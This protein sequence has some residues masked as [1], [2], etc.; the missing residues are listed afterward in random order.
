MRDEYIQAARDALEAQGG[1]VTYTSGQVTAEFYAV[2][3]PGVQMF[4]EAGQ[5]LRVTALRAITDDMV[6]LKP[7]ATFVDQETELRYE[8]L[9]TLEND[10][11][12]RQISVGRLSAEV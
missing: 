3:R 7:G 1:L 10:G 4:D 2:I 11:I 8:F 9:K 12:T 6:N 5:A